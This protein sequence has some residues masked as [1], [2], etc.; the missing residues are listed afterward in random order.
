MHPLPPNIS[1]AK[2]FYNFNTSARKNLADKMKLN[3][4]LKNNFEIEEV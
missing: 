3:Y 4:S 2:I 1:Q